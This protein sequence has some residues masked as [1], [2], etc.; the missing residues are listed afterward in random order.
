MKVGFIGFGEVAYNISKVMIRS[1][2]N[3]SNCNNNNNTNNTDNNDNNVSTTRNTLKIFSYVIGRSKKTNDLINNLANDHNNQISNKINKV[4]S[5]EELFEKS[6]IIISS[7]SPKS[8]IEVAKIA[9]SYIN[10]R[11][12]NNADNNDN[13]TNTISKIYID[14]N[15]IS[16]KTTFKIAN[17]IENKENENENENNSSNNYNNGF[18]FVDGAIIGKVS[19]NNKTENENNSENGNDNNIDNKNNLHNINIIAS[20]KYANKLDILKNYGINFK[21]ISENIGDA[22]TLKMLRSTYTKP[23]SAI[24][25]ESFENAKELGLEEELFDLI[26]ISEGE[27]FKKSAKS[28][29]N[30]SKLN[31]NRKIE[32]MEELIDFLSEVS[33]KKPNSKIVKAS[34]K[35]FES[36][37]L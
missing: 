21:V 26:G 20:G 11:N 15:N 34:K 6:E 13:N 36:V 27:E 9:N 37:E 16:P 1:I 22:S 31:S 24:L 32:E 25:I 30:N 10:K 35:V 2:D 8:A 23:L 12:K 7:V 29:I 3:E 19:N 5:Y 28:R 33:P 14:L 17:F 4:N 18:N